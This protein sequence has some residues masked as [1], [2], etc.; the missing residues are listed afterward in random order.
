LTF[1][2][3]DTHQTREAALKK[4]LQDA[5]DGINRDVEVT[6]RVLVCR[7]IYGTVKEQFLRV[8]IPYADRIRPR[9]ISDRRIIKKFLDMIRGYAIFKFMQRELDE[10]GAIIATMEDFER[11]KRL[12][13]AQKK[14]LVT[15]LNEKERN[16]LIAINQTL[17]GAD[18]NTIADKTGIPY[19]GVQR[20]IN[21]RADSQSDEGL[22]GKIKGLTVENV[23]ERYGDS[24]SKTKKVYR[25]KELNIF[26]MYESD[27]IT[28]LPE[29]ENAAEL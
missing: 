13:E 19:K 3:D 23:G 6:Y 4:T 15:K 18:L 22:L 21:G 8:K 25:L 5:V 14:G 7:A 9:D 12:F 24:V 2:T 28:L 10:D 26:E 16:I 11:A 27:F 20:I 29:P 17:G 1:T